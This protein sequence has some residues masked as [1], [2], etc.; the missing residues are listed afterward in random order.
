MPGLSDD[1]AALR[2]IDA[3]FNRAREALRV[4]EEYARFV[5]EDAS[6]SAEMKGLRHNLGDALRAFADNRSPDGPDD[7]TPPTR[8]DVT[9]SANFGALISSRDIVGDVG[10]EISVAGEYERASVESVVVAAGKRLS[11][12]LRVIE[13]YGKVIDPALGAAVEAIRYRAYE[14]ER[15]ISATMA[16]RERFGGVRLYVLLTE[17]HCL[18]DWFATAEA[19]IR[20]GAHGLQLREKGLSDR[21]LLARATRLVGLCRAHGALFIVND[22]ADIALATGADGVHVGQD[23][24][25]VAAVRRMVGPSMIVGVSTHTVEQARSAIEAAPD[26]IA[27]G[28]MFESPTKPQPHIAGRKT[29]QEVRAMTGLPLA[30]IGGITA[31]TAGDVLAAGATVLCVCQAVIG[32]ADVEASARELRTLLDRH[33]ENSARQPPSARSASRDSQLVD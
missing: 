20:G 13:E 17:G 28:P 29:L 5:L 15:R 30:A 9:G 25:P 4:M 33:F 22:R 27:V 2:I 1:S 3:N 16:A 11:E 23:D 31:E 32:A 8:G 18:G 7:S 19:A 12:A 21:E 6:L 14:V 10:R 24:L 26:Y